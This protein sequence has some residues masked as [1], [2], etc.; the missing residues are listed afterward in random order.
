MILVSACLVGENCKYSGGN[1]MNY[2]IISL[3]KDKRILPMCPE[4]LGGLPTPRTPAEIVGGDGCSVLLGHG[5]VLCQNNVNVTPQYLKGTEIV[6]K[7]AENNK[8]VLAIM[9]ERSPSCGVQQIYDGSFSGKT[10]KGSGVCTAALQKLGIPVISE[11]T[12]LTNAILDIIT[13]AAIHCPEN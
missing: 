5:K 8:V 1:N 2:K 13:K 7:A 6:K 11:E 3:L 10:I 12:V 4:E 9:K